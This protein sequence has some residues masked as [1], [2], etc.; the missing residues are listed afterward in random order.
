MAVQTIVL[1]SA[2]M[3]DAARS[4]R[5]LIDTGANEVVRP[6]H[7]QWWAEMEAG[8][9]YGRKISCSLAGG[10][11]AIAY[12]TRHGEVTIN[13]PPR[14]KTVGW[15]LPVNRIVK[16]LGVKLVWGS[17]GVS[18]VCPDKRVFHAKMEGGLPYI[19]Y[20]SFSPL[21]S[22]L[23]ESHRNGRKMYQAKVNGLDVRTALEVVEASRVHVHQD[24]QGGGIEEESQEGCEIL[25]ASTTKGT[26]QNPPWHPDKMVWL[27]ARKW[28]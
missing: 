11:Q 18:L 23:I 22:A 24:A 15:I 12:I 13:K 6:F 9:A 7:S 2:E 20:E 8:D 27:T 19:D 17:E 14:N 3:I 16:E 21:R 1:H 5:V 28:S 25:L 4:K 26:M 10:H